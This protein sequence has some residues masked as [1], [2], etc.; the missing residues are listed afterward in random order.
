M[1]LLGPS[2]SPLPPQTREEGW[3]RTGRTGSLPAEL[4][5]PGG[6]D[7]VNG[8]AGLARREVP[9]VSA[10]AR[11]SA[12]ILEAVAVLLTIAF[13]GSAIAQV[14]DLGSGLVLLLILVCSAV[15]ASI[16]QFAAAVRAPGRI[17][18]SGWGQAILQPWRALRMIVF[19]LLI[20]LA[21]LTTSAI[22]LIM[23]FIAM[24]ILH[25]YLAA[26]PGSAVKKRNG[27]VPTSP[28][29]SLRGS[30]PLEPFWNQQVAKHRKVASLRRLPK[31]PISR[32]FV[33]NG[34]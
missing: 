1:R 10:Q 26:L 22:W 29:S 21:T 28:S 9:V 11:Y 32:G 27:G 2:L 13:F 18:S 33:N 12:T 25:R 5:P 20:V 30:E 14:L 16:A 8:A 15:G 6:S 24:A 4:L 34:N 7:R 23:I 17:R 31:L 19:G 3:E